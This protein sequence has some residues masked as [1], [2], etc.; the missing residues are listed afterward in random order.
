MVPAQMLRRDVGN[1]S[2][3]PVFSVLAASL[4]ES[5]ELCRQQRWNFLNWNLIL[6]RLQRNS[7]FRFH[8][9]YF[10]LLLEPF[11]NELKKIVRRMFSE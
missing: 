4:L 9:G 5:A 11:Y 8:I 6:M 2:V 10:P 3:H 1:Y 7:Q